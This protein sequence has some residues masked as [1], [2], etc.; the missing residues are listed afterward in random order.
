MKKLLIASILAA[1]SMAASAEGWYVGGAIGQASVEGVEAYAQEAMTTQGGRSAQ[2]TDGAGSSKFI[3]GYA[4][5]NF[6][7]LEAGFTSFGSQEA[8]VQYLGGSEHNEWDMSAIFIEV[9]G[10]LPIGESFSLLGKVG[11]AQTN[12][13]YTYTDTVGGYIKTDKSKG[14]SKF[15]FGGEYVIAKKYAIRAEF[16]RYLDVGAQFAYDTAVNKPSDVDVVS[17]G[18]NYKF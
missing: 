18:F 17:V 7:A 6:F 14:T 2:Y 1:T 4:L 3:G 16:E 11:Y 12:T 10:M 15:G 8:D 5:N 13:E 9:V